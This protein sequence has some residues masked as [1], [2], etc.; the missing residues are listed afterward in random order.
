MKPRTRQRIKTY[1]AEI[2]LAGG[3]IVGVGGQFL[4]TYISNYCHGRSRD[5]AE[6]IEELHPTDYEAR[7]KDPLYKEYQKWYKRMNYASGGQLVGLLIMTGTV[8]AYLGHVH[9]YAR[10]QDLEKKIKEEVEKRLKDVRQQSA[11]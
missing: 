9:E 1:A 4:G 6:R 10:D 7:A 2:L 3:L 5:L 8:L 11:L